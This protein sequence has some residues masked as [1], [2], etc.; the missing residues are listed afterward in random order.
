M[1]SMR[2]YNELP[3]YHRPRDGGMR[4]R[5]M[6]RGP[7]PELREKPEEPRGPATRAECQRRIRAWEDKL[8]HAG[9]DAA[10]AAV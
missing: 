10:F 8:A 7:A 4:C 9:G 6:P 5:T 2:A 3:R 1:R